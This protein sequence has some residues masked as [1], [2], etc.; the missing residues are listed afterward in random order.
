MKKNKN[1]QE[2]DTASAL[3]NS[4]L[5][6]GPHITVK[7]IKFY[8]IEKSLP[9]SIIFLINKYNI[10]LIFSNPIFSY[11]SHLVQTYE[12]GDHTDNSLLSCLEELKEKDGIEISYSI[13]SLNVFRSKF[14]HTALAKCILSHLLLSL[15]HECQI[16]ITSKQHKKVTRKTSH[17]ILKS[18]LKKGLTEGDGKNDVNSLVD[19]KIK[20]FQELFDEFIPLRLGD[21]AYDSSEYDFYISTSENTSHEIDSIIPESLEEIADCIYMDNI[22]P[23]KLFKDLELAKF[24]K[25]TPKM[26]KIYK[27]LL[28]ELLSKRNIYA[29]DQ[30]SNSYIHYQQFKDVDDILIHLNEIEKEGDDIVVLGAD[31]ILTLLAYYEENDKTFPKDMLSVIEEGKVRYTCVPNILSFLSDRGYRDF[32]KN[33]LLNIISINKIIE[34]FAFSKSYYAQCSPENLPIYDPLTLYEED[35]WKFYIQYHLSLAQYLG[36]DVLVLSKELI[37][38]V[39]KRKMEQYPFLFN[40]NGNTVSNN[41][42]I[43]KTSTYRKEFNIALRDY[44]S[45]SE[46]PVWNQL[47][48]LQYNFN[49]ISIPRSFFEVYLELDQ[50]SQRICDSFWDSQNHDDLKAQL[51]KYSEQIRE[52]EQ[53]LCDDDNYTQELDV[54][55][56]IKL[57]ISNEY[58]YLNKITFYFEQVKHRMNEGKIINIHHLYWIVGYYKMLIGNYLEEHSGKL[59]SSL[60]RLINSTEETREE[61]ESIIAFLTIEDQNGEPFP[62][63]VQTIRKSKIQLIPHYLDHPSIIK[64][65]LNSFLL[66]HYIFSKTQI[67][68]LYTEFKKFLKI[69]KRFNLIYEKLSYRRFEE[70]LLELIPQHLAYNQ[71][72]GFYYSKMLKEFLCFASTYYRNEQKKL[73]FKDISS[74]FNLT[75]PQVEIFIYFLLQNGNLFKPNN[76]EF[77][78]LRCFFLN[79]INKEHLIKE[80]QNSLLSYGDLFI[81][82]R[83]LHNFFIIDNGKKDRFLSQPLFWVF[84]QFDINT[85]IKSFYASP[86]GKSLRSDTPFRITIKGQSFSTYLDSGFFIS[87]MPRKFADEFF[88]EKKRKTVII[89]GVLNI[90]KKCNFISDVEFYVNDQIY[91]DK[92]LLKNNIKENFK[93]DIVL[94]LDAINKIL[95]RNYGVPFYPLF[96]K[97]KQEK[98]NDSQLLLPNI[99]EE[100]K[101]NSGDDISKNSNVGIHK[102]HINPK[103]ID[104][105][106]PTSRSF[107]I[108]QKQIKEMESMVEEK[109]RYSTESIRISRAKFDLKEVDRLA[110]R[111]RALANDTLYLLRQYYFYQ[112][113]KDTEKKTLY[114]KSIESKF[115][116]IIKESE[117]PTEKRERAIEILDGLFIRLKALKGTIPTIMKFMNSYDEIGYTGCAQ[118]IVKS[119]CEIFIGHLELIRKYYKDLK[120]WGKTAEDR[121]GLKPSQPGLPQ[122]FGKKVKGER[123]GKW[124]LVY[125]KQA[126]QHRKN[127]ESLKNALDSNRYTCNMYVP[128]SHNHL[129]PPIRVRTKVLRQ[130]LDN[131]GFVEIIPKERNYSFNIH[132]IKTQRQ[133]AREYSLDLNRYRQNSNRA[134]SI[135]FGVNNFLTVFNNF[136]ARFPIF[137]ASAIKRWNY[138]VNH[139]IPKLQRRVDVLTD[140]LERYEKNKKAGRLLSLESIINSRIHTYHDEFEILKQMILYIFRRIFELSKIDK[141]GL[142]EKDFFL[143][144]FRSKLFYGTVKNTNWNNFKKL[145]EKDGKRVYKGIFNKLRKFILMDLAPREKNSLLDKYFHYLQSKRDYKVRILR[146]IFG[147]PIQGLRDY[148]ELLELKID[149][150]WD[151]YNRVKRD[152]I[153]K[154]AKKLMYYCLYYGVGTITFG[155]NKGWQGNT[156]KLNKVTRDLFVSLPFSQIFKR[157]QVEAV[158]FG[159]KVDYTPEWF[160][161]KCS[162]IDEESI[163]KKAD[164][165]YAGLRRF[166]QNGVKHKG[167]FRTKDGKIVHGDING[168]ANIGRK[169]HPELFSKK[170]I[171]YNLGLI[172]DLRRPIND[173]IKRL[174][175]NF[176]MT[177]PIKF[178]SSNGIPTKKLKRKERL[179]KSKV[180]PQRYQMSPKRFLTMTQTAYI[181]SSTT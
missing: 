140:V 170:M 89:S 12:E 154:I 147:Y 126:F 176:I 117:Y 41:I 22:S 38:I 50:N 169:Q 124:K 45:P 19:L 156:V 47:F 15:S 114:R 135:D 52:N 1:E 78:V 134:I 59:S 129:I 131:G 105:K 53:R 121:G 67:E 160:T 177:P 27:T 128:P 167:L 16:Y 26:K 48:S 99:N 112:T 174:V 23:T 100:K 51:N 107:V 64:A 75:L 118:Q 36:A 84:S 127:L 68:S 175:S 54:F 130:L 165:E 113:T 92:F 149:K 151:K 30:S 39:F 102:D 101:K 28:A 119:V 150:L 116:K 138:K 77:G 63:Q 179:N 86:I 7:L 13:N 163:G 4:K 82:E 17:T 98:I 72:S 37:M 3:R 132:Y 168:A 93:T 136:G 153:N 145:A 57:L 2:S 74:I 122:Y 97:I 104:N 166:T 70:Y 83:Q 157:I 18:S 146:K 29:K 76:S 14:P 32:T 115:Y 142:D 20:T 106:Q 91:T 161:S 66:I 110:D 158:Y 71:A 5:F 96:K 88:P 143:K 181:Y 178:S 180:K 155:Y 65:L 42:K 144:C 80:T 103:P 49:L 95:M 9:K 108:N 81:H 31:F 33:F 90:P 62:L 79:T 60:K 8:L 172:S 85:V 137:K 58:E 173:R 152:N 24:G 164:E 61:L 10:E 109:G 69:D 73:L 46:I 111:S 6:L 133:R 35:Y 40:V 162:F 125:T 21:M 123:V 44:P 11:I 159:I 94:G 141:A 87:I 25:K 120:K 148:L 43:I 171:A 56:N 34:A 55:N 139:T